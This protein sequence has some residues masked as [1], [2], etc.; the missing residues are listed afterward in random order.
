MS[1]L[2]TGECQCRVPVGLDLSI[3][4]AAHLQERLDS[5]DVAVHSSQ[6]QGRNAQLGARTRVDLSGMGQ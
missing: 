6:H 5:G 3:D 4:V 2:E 1:P